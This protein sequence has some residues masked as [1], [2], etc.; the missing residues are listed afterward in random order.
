M[1][2]RRIWWGVGI[3]VCGLGA[4][5]P[6]RKTLL[7]NEDLDQV[8]REEFAPVPILGERRQ[9]PPALLTAADSGD[10]SPVET[11]PEESLALEPLTAVLERGVAARA[12]DKVDEVDDLVPLPAL[13]ASYVPQA[14][15]A[16][17]DPRE[18]TLGDRGTAPSVTAARPPRH[19]RIR[20]NDT[21]EDIAQRLLGSP[22][23]ADKLL[24]ANPG[25]I[26][27]PEI[28]PVGATII[29]PDLSQP[30]PALVQLPGAQD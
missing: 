17:A 12:M 19:Y 14:E 30:S 24:A 2:N 11:L 4:A 10:P 9:P 27:V 18:P 29:V 28:L 3:I 5:W 7:T 6:F 8:L 22:Q 1:G 23:H 15:P 13:S 25:V 20:K 16:A 21:L 26:L